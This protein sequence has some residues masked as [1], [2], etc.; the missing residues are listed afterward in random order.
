MISIALNPLVFKAVEPARS[1]I[2]SRSAFARRLER[3]ADPLAELPA[4]VQPAQVTGHVVLVGYGGVGR[5][6]GEELARHVAEALSR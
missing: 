1:W 3:R 2:R 5:G 4:S 6:L